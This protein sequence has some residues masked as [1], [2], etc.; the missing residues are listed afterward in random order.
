MVTRHWLLFLLPGRSPWSSY[1]SSWVPAQYPAQVCLQAFQSS[2]PLTFLQEVWSMALLCQSP[3]LLL[4]GQAQLLLLLAFLL[5]HLLLLL[6]TQVSGDSV[7]LTCRDSLSPHRQPAPTHSP[8][9]EAA[10]AV[11]RAP[12]LSGASSTAF[13]QAACLEMSNTVNILRRALLEKGHIN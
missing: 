13:A 9:A 5:C 10:A 11:S 6:R 8:S 3:P 2:A 1:R 7:G 4:Q 12:P